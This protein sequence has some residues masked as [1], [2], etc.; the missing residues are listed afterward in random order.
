M[1]IVDHGFETST[2]SNTLAYFNGASMTMKNVFCNDEQC[3]GNGDKSRENSTEDDDDI[4]AES[5]AK[6]VA[7]RD[8]VNCDAK[9]SRLDDASMAN[10]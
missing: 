8:V 4:D 2:G 10:R 1:K 9:S 3:N 5:D 6:N 7:K